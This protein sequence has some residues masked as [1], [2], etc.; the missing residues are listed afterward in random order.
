MSRKSIIPPIALRIPENVD[1]FVGYG[2]H[3]I[4]CFK[5]NQD[6]AGVQPTVAQV[7]TDFGNLATAE[8]Q[9]KNKVPGAIE[10]REELYGTCKTDMELWA[11]F[12]HGVA[13]ANPGRAAQIVASSGFGERKQVVQKNRRPRVAFP[14]PGTAHVF[15]PTPK[16]GASF[17]WQISADGGATFV[18]AGNTN[19][20][21]QIFKGL[22]KGTDY[23]VRWQTTIGHTTSSWSQVF[24]FMQ[25][26]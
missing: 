26:K 20:A 12:A 15:V 9:A 5:G 24:S 16:R 10:K 22:K 17:A 25:E 1:E 23:E 3:K 2:Q 7:T 19:V 21:D 11:A 14:E 13:M 8:G 18:A 4:Q 6:L